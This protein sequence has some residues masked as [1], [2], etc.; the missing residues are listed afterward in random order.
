MSKDIIINGET[1][2]GVVD[3]AL[4]TSGGTALFRDVDEI[5]ES[6]APA[7]I[8]TTATTS[9]TTAADVWNTYV[10]PNVSAYPAAAILTVEN[11]DTTDNLSVVSAVIAKVSETAGGV[12]SATRKDGM[13]E[14]A[15]LSNTGLHIAIGASVTVT[16]LGGV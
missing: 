10:K 7:V 6:G 5:P 4:P 8:T 1:Y 2:S 3:V 11:N 13:K 14:Q 12:V 15:G 16:I 9:S